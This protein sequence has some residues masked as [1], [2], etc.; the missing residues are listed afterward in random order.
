MCKSKN[1]HVKCTEHGLFKCSKFVSL[2]NFQCQ[3]PWHQNL[4]CHRSVLLDQTPLQ[5]DPWEV[6]NEREDGKGQLFEGGYY[7]KYF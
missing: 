5:L 2:I 4:N 1:D 6:I 3:Y 7:F